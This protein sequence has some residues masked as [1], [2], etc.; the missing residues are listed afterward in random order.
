MGVGIRASDD[1][2]HSPLC[3]RICC[4]CPAFRYE[5]FRTEWDAPTA[6]HLVLDETPIGTWA[7]LEGTPQWI[8]E[9]LAKLR[10]PQD[11]C[12]VKSYGVLFLDWKAT[13]HS[14]AEN[15]TFEEIQPVAV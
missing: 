3:H 14:P 12:T 7:E 8:D 6:G 9:M 10:V 11:R 4:F 15:L 1:D 5:K 2:T 13:N